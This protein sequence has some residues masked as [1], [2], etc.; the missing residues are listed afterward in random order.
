ME[1]VPDEADEA[2]GPDSE[3]DV[4]GFPVYDLPAGRVATGVMVIIRSYDTEDPAQ[5]PALSFR[6]SDGLA[7][8]EAEAML[9]NALRDAENTIADEEGWA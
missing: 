8:W 4:F 9:R 5:V 6:G 2:R 3:V 1:F 7:M